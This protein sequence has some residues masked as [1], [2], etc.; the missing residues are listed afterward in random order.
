MGGGCD[1]GTEVRLGR[2]QEKVEDSRW[3]GRRKKACTYP[4]NSKCFFTATGS[5]A[6]SDDARM[7][8]IGGVA[9]LPSEL[10]LLYTYRNVVMSK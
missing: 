3:D 7:V 2:E 8:Y 6:R 10:S 9:A 4:T 5:F 1:P